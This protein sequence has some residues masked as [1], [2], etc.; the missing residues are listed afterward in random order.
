MSDPRQ[1]ILFDGASEAAEAHS[2]A[3]GPAAERPE[4][5]HD[6]RAA[7]A[8]R[9][10]DLF[11]AAG[12][13]TGKTAVLVERFCDAVCDDGAGV[14]NI[15][16]FTFTDRAAAELT[17]RV[18][19]ALGE[20]AAEEKDLAAARRLRELA[21]D[22]ES[23]WISTIHAFCRRA[24]AAHPFAAGLDPGFDVLDETEAARLGAEAFEAA[25]RRF[26]ERGGDDRFEMAAAF[27]VDGLREIVRSAYDELRA[28]GE[29]RPALPA[30]APPDP[31]EAL[32]ALRAAANDAL[33]ALREAGDTTPVRTCRDRIAAAI[34][35][36]E[37][38][39]PEE[40]EVDEWKDESSA[41]ALRL[42]EV[43]R[44][45]EAHGVLARRVVEARFAHHY[46]YLR[47]LV[48]LYGEELQRIKD[49]RGALD[50]E[51]LQ[52]RAR[53][54]LS[55]RS[56]IRDR[57]RRQF[58]H[59]M[60]DEFQ[61]TNELQ[62]AIV[63]LLHDG[64]EGRLFTVGDELQSIYG[65]RHADVEVFRGVRRA[66]EE[67][68]AAGVRRLAGSF[69]SAPP[70]LA[71]VNHLGRAL[72][73]ADYEDLEMGKEPAEAPP[74][75]VLVVER[76]GWDEESRNGVSLDERAQP[77][78][79]AE[80]TFL[81]TRLAEL[82]RE[83]VPRGDMVV[84]LRSFSYVEA[85]ESALEESG[86]AP[87]VVGGRG[88]WSKQQVSDVRNLLACVANPLD[89]KALFG[90]LASPAC[91]AGSDAIWLLRHAAYRRPVWS[92]LRRLYG[93]DAGSDPAEAGAQAEAGTDEVE[94]TRRERERA[95]REHVPAA[96]AGALR[97][98]T[99][100][101]LDLRAE[102][103]RL[104][105]AELIERTISV[106]DYDLALLMRGR[107]RRRMANVRKLMRLAGE[108]EAGERRD[109]RA[110][111]DFVDAEVEAEGRES[112][113]AVDAE[114]PD[115]VRI[116]TV[117]AAKGLEFPIV[118]VA[119]LGRK[120]TM[121]FPPALR[122]EA[123]PPRAASE[124]EGDGAA[125]R[126]GLR[127]A[128]LGRPGR[129]IFDFAELQKEADER[130]R[131]EERRILHVAMTRARRRLVLSGAFEL[132]KL[133]AEPKDQDPLIATVLRA[134]GQPWEER[135]LELEP[136]APREGLDARPGPTRVEVR[137]R[138][139][140][141][142]PVAAATAPS[143]EHHGGALRR[144]PMPLHDLRPRAAE[145][146]P[147]VR[148]VSY[149]A[150]ALYERCGYR[151]YAERV[152][153]LS[154]RLPR[155]RAAPGRGAPRAAFRSD[156]GDGPGPERDAVEAGDEWH[157]GSGDE[158]L[159]TRYAR[160]RVVHALLERSAREG[161][162][163]PSTE[164]AAELLRAEGVE[165]GAQA[166]RAVALVE[167]FLG[168]ALRRELEGAAALHPEAPFAFRAAR[169]VVRGEIDVL[170]RLD[171]EVLVVDYKSD[172]L[173]GAPPLDHM[174]R[175][176]A[177]RRI[178]A[179]AALRRYGLP[180]RVAYAFL[181]R[182]DAPVEA[183]FRPDDVPRLEEGLE[184]A[185]AGIAARRFEVTSAPERSLCLDC[186]ARENLCS[187]DASMTLREPGAAA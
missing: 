58:R 9:Q 29:A 83:G 183:R 124:P 185:C 107:G 178:Y 155:G 18:R 186:P 156:D 150:L 147:P 23:A 110:F 175:Y 95:A 43:E 2:T 160:G 59:V 173:A 81:A 98:F 139:P 162:A 16:A 56:D 93:P 116:M 114:G 174:D 32:T 177:Q 50:Y 77:W 165:G 132:D 4:P 101:L 25:F 27:R 45:R 44:Y 119:D 72:F 111:L 131:R 138:R 66:M 143:T 152:L 24:L 103:P 166:E 89:D 96:D 159:S 153:G 75:E 42:P 67:D 164:H 145:A 90:A 176:D 35:G 31:D 39:L 73:G 71:L 69:R 121:G 141:D 26:G 80:A 37:G 127:L 52:L 154:P 49:A 22:S 179:L 136:P 64:G 87:H 19:H 68:R 158:D 129:R 30:L 8:D 120:L 79:V 102:A 88:Y 99:A 115:G 55:A 10:R 1:G 108:F 157:P 54:M 161:F 92:A 184:A 123:A 85:Y 57:Y 86:L 100:R 13:G 112:E 48:E 15:L 38:G 170:A 109:L 180:V 65:F 142:G 106:F 21:R 70:V 33:A 36:T 118:A 82:H 40:A 135:S 46:D 20:R 97:G 17:R 148:Q 134:L 105:L 137:V 34:A 149:S 133:D 62:L 125:P 94:E 172:A 113:A 12:A 63:R 7:I 128:R 182:P 53:D 3:P 74:A 167:G 78:R 11:L 14:E 61:D 76:D 28:R 140:A 169:L 5:V 146:P 168:S 181:E 41:A 47:E 126:V 122:L 84:L 117:H 104:S 187:H 6:Q 163:P 60:V 144:V 151:F 51:D 171:G 130:E 91:G